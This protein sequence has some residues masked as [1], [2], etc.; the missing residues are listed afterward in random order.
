MKRILTRVV[1]GVCFF[2]FI[3]DRKRCDCDNCNSIGK[4]NGKGRCSTQFARLKNEKE[5]W[6][7]GARGEKKP[8][9]RPD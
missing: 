5:N 3:T 4:K 2:F 7:Q 1:M 9:F 8:A 6:K